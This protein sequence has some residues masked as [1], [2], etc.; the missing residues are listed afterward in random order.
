M[1]KFAA[2]WSHHPVP[3]TI[4]IAVGICVVIGFYLGKMRSPQEYRQFRKRHRKIIELIKKK[5]DGRLKDEEISN[6]NISEAKALL[7]AY[8]DFDLE[9]S[10][11][12]AIDAT[13]F[14]L[15]ETDGPHEGRGRNE[16]EAFILRAPKT[17]A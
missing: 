5:S 10:K 6:R 13:G 9:W 17:Q 11:V 1:H 15:D 7:R 8:Q 16:T 12:R 14:S 3:F 2:A 4:V